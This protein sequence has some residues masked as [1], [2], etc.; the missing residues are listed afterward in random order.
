MIWG[1][2]QDAVCH[3]HQPTVEALK[4]KEGTKLDGE[5]KEEKRVMAKGEGGEGSV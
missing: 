2:A 5:V 1:L 4:E 3:L